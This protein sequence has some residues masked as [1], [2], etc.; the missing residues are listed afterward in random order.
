M[1]SLDF[2]NYSINLNYNGY[3]NHPSKIGIILSIMVGLLCI[4]FGIYSFRELW[5]R[6]KPV[7]KLVSRYQPDSGIN[8]FGFGGINH[9]L[10]IKK[11]GGAIIDFDER[12]VTVEAINMKLIGDILGI[13]TYKKCSWEFNGEDFH[14]LAGSNV[15]KS[16]FDMSVCIKTFY[17][18]TS[19]ETIELNNQTKSF[20]PN[21]NISH[22]TGS[23]APLP[24]RTLFYIN[25][26]ECTNSTTKNDCYPKEQIQQ[27]YND[28]VFVLG[29]IDK[30]FDITNY[31]HPIQNEFN[32][33]EGLM[34]DAS[35]ITNHLDFNPASV[36]SNDGLIFDEIRKS[37]SIYLFQN[38]KVQIN[39]ADSPIIAQANFWLKN[40][41]T[42]YSRNYLKFQDLLASIGGFM[43]FI[44][45]L[46]LFL[47]HFPGKLHLLYETVE[48]LSENNFSIANN[49]S[50]SF[51]DNTKNNNIINSK[52]EVKPFSQKMRANIPISNLEIID[53]SSFNVKVD[54]KSNIGNNQDKNVIDLNPIKKVIDLPKNTQ[55]ELT[56]EGGAKKSVLNVS[57]FDIVLDSLKIS[58]Y[59]E[60]SKV[61]SL[62]DYI[63]SENNL[64]KLY[65]DS[66]KN[67]FEILKG[68]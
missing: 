4:A 51:L 22:G 46:A 5:E 21:A 68:A 62:R 60:I 61:E 19:G 38:Q 28:K 66:K 57:I 3:R 65:F 67:S 18:Q 42:V 8:H 9:F 36:E 59:P 17:N 55:M 64:F 63:I 13:Y 45:Y 32:K 7:S 31:K 56:L 48:L 44:Y 6:K 25:L 12:A 14:P 20:F 54:D 26:K 40:Q 50:S 39:K 47:N 58:R 16:S 34:S 29:F 23:S 41:E 10:H 35:I 15:D 33:I 24:L 11:R 43:N 27:Y 49:N 2:I 1:K 52:K 30:K 37:N 53:C